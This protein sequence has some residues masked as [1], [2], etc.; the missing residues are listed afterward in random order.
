MKLMLKRKITQILVFIMMISMLSACGTSQDPS[1][2]T[3]GNATSNA[4]TASGDQ[5]T[6]ATADN[7]GGDT[8]TISF[9]IHVANL[10]DQEPQIYEVLQ[11]FMALNQDIVIDIIATSNA[12]EQTTQMKLAAESGMLPDVLWLQPSTSKEMFEAG[13][14]MDLSKFLDYDAKVNAA[15]GDSLRSLNEDGTPNEDGT[16]IG[17]PYQKLVTGF[18]INKDV[19]EK[20]GLDI[21]HSG[22]T[23]EEF[24]E[25]VKTFNSNGVTTISNGAKTPYSI[26]AF[27]SAWVRY[28]FL[29]HLNGIRDGSDS[30]VNDDF[31]RYF[32]MIDQ[33][34]QAGAFPSNITTQDYFQAKEAFLSGNAA[35]LDSGQWDSSEINDALGDASGF[36]WGPTF[37]DGVGDQRIGMQAFTSNLRVSAKVE[38]DPVKKDAVFRFLSYWLSEEADIIRVQYGTNPITSNP[39]VKVENKAYSAMLAAIA[40]EGWRGS[41]LQ[42]DQIVADVVKSAIHDAVYG[43][44][45]GIYTPQQACETVQAA[46]ERTM[47]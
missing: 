30:F 31:L 32:E 40:D 22:T 43:V 14:L 39:D 1:S 16:V 44:M 47:N 36:W 5:S 12:D 15:I 25:M 27:Q 2:G 11:S 26:W 21:P 29:D 19:F 41:P 28:G 24:L 33:L 20:Y 18:W 4:A 23:F 46:Q 38:D 10:Q 37:A 34:R 45:S 35:M 7:S 8:V 42:P 9:G 6:P 13:Y 3:D 17:L